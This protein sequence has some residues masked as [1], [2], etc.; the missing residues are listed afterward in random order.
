MNFMIDE[1][2]KNPRVVFDQNKFLWLKIG[3]F[4]I[5]I[6]LISQIRSS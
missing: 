4:K 2:A 1:K 6:S 3:K 5:R